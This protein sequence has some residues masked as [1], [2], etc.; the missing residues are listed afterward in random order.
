MDNGLAVSA[1][2]D[3]DDRLPGRHCLQ[4]SEP[5]V[6]VLRRR[7][8][9]SAGGVQVDQLRIIDFPEEFHVRGRVE[10]S[11]EPFHAYAHLRTPRDDQPLPG[12]PTEH[13]H[14]EIDALLM[15]EPVHGQPEVADAR[16]SVAP[17]VDGRI[18]DLGRSPEEPSDSVRH[19]SAV[20]DDCVDPLN[21]GF[22][23][24][25]S[26]LDPSARGRASD[27]RE[28]F[29][30]GVAEVVKHPDGRV[31]IPEIRPESRCRKDGPIPREDVHVVVGNRGVAEGAR[32]RV[33]SHRCLLRHARDF[34]RPDGG[35]AG[36]LGKALI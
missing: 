19:I 10:G 11:G 25:P 5:E 26:S 24:R 8:E 13:L 2:V 17:R 15:R 33:L 12:Q 35:H 4:G 22:V 31:A 29:E 32:L 30:N 7:N 27:R 18:D 34:G 9:S 1:F 23:L 21:G 20:R 16:E 3:R 6:L 36:S 14:L 28:R